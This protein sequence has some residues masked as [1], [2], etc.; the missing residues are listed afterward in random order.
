MWE[1]EMQ[2][3]PEIFNEIATEKYVWC[4]AAKPFASLNE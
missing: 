3:I 2:S 1:S 4:Y